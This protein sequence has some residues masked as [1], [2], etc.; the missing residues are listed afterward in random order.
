MGAMST[1]LTQ[2]GKV[3]DNQQDDRNALAAQNTQLQNQATNGSSLAQAQMQQATNQ[4][5]QQSAGMMA[6]A[7][8]IN[9]AMA[10]RTAA[11]NNATTGQTAANQSAQTTA[12]TQLASQSQLSNNLNNEY[13]ADSGSSNQLNALNYQQNQYNAGL[14]MQYAKMAS[15]A[16]GGAMMGGAAGGMV[17]Q[18]MAGGGMMGG[19]DKDINTEIQ[20]GMTNKNS[21]A[22][23]ISKE[24]Q[25]Q[26]LLQ[27][28]DPYS[29]ISSFFNSLSQQNNSEPNSKAGQLMAAGDNG[30]SSVSGPV[31]VGTSFRNL[32][33]G[34]DDNA[35][36]NPESSVNPEEAASGQQSY[37]RGG[38]TRKVP[39]LVSPGETYLKPAQAKAVAKG[40]ADP[41][42]VGERIPGTPKVAGNSYANDTVPKKLDAGGVV[43]PNSIMQSSDPAH[44][45]YKFVQ[46]VMAQQRAKGKK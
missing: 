29:T 35:S 7:K 17:P 5:M 24:N 12:Q 36:D 25:A 26:P 10:A 14:A 11:Y 31:S 28:Q 42:K 38:Q 21:S 4:N 30:L 40:K 44:N 41:L 20:A 9:P 37:A 1:T 15:S 6:S 19:D 43:I 18:K 27:T 46:A 39:A 22:D 16:I 23:I 8:G 32:L 33:S 13:N 3:F 2:Q 34:Q 45:A